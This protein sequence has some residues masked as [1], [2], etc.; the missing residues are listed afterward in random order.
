M[1]SWRMQAWTEGRWRDEDFHAK[2]DTARVL[3]DP[4]LGRSAKASRPVHIAETSGNG[5]EASAEAQREAP[6]LEA[7]AVEM[8]AWDY[9]LGGRFKPPP[10][11]TAVELPIPHF[12]P[13]SRHQALGRDPFESP[14][15]RG[16]EFK[17]RMIARLSGI[18]SPWGK[19]KLVRILWDMF[20]EH[21][22]A[23]VYRVWLDLAPHIDD[24]AVVQLGIELKQLWEDTPA[25]WLYRVAPDLPPRFHE[26]A[27]LHFSW[28][29]AFRIAAS[30]PHERADN[31]LNP[32]GLDDWLDL[33]GPCPGFWSFAKYVETA[34]TGNEA[35]LAAF[36]ALCRN[37]RRR[38]FDRT[39]EMLGSWQGP[40]SVAR[41]HTGSVGPD[42][43]RSMARTYETWLANL[44]GREPCY[45]SS[46][47]KRA[48]RKA[49]K[50]EKCP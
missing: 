47:L 7:D 24:P 1:S 44:E 10:P 13:F 46:R 33:E 48:N 39:A 6:I 20:E 8:K 11:I 32:R 22:S 4:W 41:L 34:A 28:R 21:P 50:K 27:R 12:D 17:S 26:G 23:Q 43:V 42:Q 2:P 15:L 25:Y 37:R 5:A 29:G 49:R 38:L 9:E 18:A 14:P 40:R 3:V 30:L 45:T 19:A 31:L 36:Q 35:E 16:A